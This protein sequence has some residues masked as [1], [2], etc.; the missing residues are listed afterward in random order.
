M[1]EDRPRCAWRDVRSALVRPQVAE[2]GRRQLGVTHGV[3]DVLVPEIGLLGARVGAAVGQR[4]AASMATIAIAAD[5]LPRSEV[6]TK[7]DLGY[8]SRCYWHS[9]LN[10][11]PVKGWVAL[12][13]F[14]RAIWISA[15]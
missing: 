5:R 9:I 3:L 6:N 8:S 12:D 1:S 11:L 14:T 4:I 2:T 13:L 10:S 7:D 15:D